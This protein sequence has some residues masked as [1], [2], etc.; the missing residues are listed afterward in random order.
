MPYK[1]VEK[2]KAKAKEYQQ[3]NKETIN[4]YARKYRANPDNRN[5]LRSIRLKYRYKIT[6]EEY[7]RMYNAQAG[8]CKVCGLHST[9]FDKPL[10]VDHCHT[11][12]KVRGLL[13]HKC[14]VAIGLF[15]DDLEKIKSA[16]RYLEEN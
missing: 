9:C 15:D 2:R 8:C 16:I 6:P 11:T 12:E 1:D 3:N 14:N 10:Y 4:E 13:C 5:K 7:D